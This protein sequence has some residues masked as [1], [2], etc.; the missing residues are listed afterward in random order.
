MNN[1]LKKIKKFVKN[2]LIPVISNIQWLEIPPQTYVRWILAIIV[3]LNTI[4]TFLDVNP[5][6]Y[7]ETQIYETVTIVLNVI[8]LAV[9]TYKNN[10]T[11][12]EAL[13]ADQLMRALKMAATTDEDTATERVIEILKDLNKNNG[14]DSDLDHTNDDIFMDE[15]IIYDDDIIFEEDEED[16]PVG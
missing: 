7:S 1:I 11:S 16:E 12:K 5:I 9:N 15:Y 6:T 14:L 4:L 3:S 10:S 2:G 8:I 13:L